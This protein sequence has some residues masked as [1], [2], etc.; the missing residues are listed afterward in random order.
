M[1]IEYTGRNLQI[2]DDVRD[3]TSSKI[4]KLEKF[5]TEPAEAH[6]ILEVEKNRKIAELQVS[7]KFGSLVAKEDAEKLL[8][9]IQAVIEKVEKQ[10]R[11]AHKKAKGNKRRGSSIRDNEAHWPMEVIDP[12]S[13]GGG[14]PRVVKASRL[15]IKPMSIEEAALQLE[16]SKNDFFVFRDSTTDKVSVLYRRRDQ[17]YGLIAPEL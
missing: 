11:R 10:A 3:F 12:Q 6:L 17:N 13:F 4:T 16:D 5:V 1:Q 7:H 8:D 14:S 15:P 2:R 9:A